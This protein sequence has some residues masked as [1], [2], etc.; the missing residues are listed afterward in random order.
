MSQPGVANPGKPAGSAATSR[1]PRG[2]ISGRSVSDFT[3]T[4]VSPRFFDIYRIGNH[5]ATRLCMSPAM[6][7]V[8]DKPCEIGVYR[9]SKSVW[10]CIGSLPKVGRFR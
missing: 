9:Q 3:L 4:N 6:V 5:L 8:W 7:M 2:L 1:L 10:I